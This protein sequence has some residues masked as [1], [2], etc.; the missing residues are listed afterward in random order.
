M[1]QKTVSKKLWVAVKVQRG[2]ICKAKVYESFGSA[3]TIV[4][5]WQ[6]RLNPDYDEA[7]V[8]EAS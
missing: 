6:S 8:I 7:A 4:R 3:R 2:F 5:R 1:K